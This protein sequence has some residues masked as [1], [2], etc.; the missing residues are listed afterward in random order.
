MMPMAI[1]MIL[2]PMVNTKEPDAASSELFIL[3]NGCGLIKPL[4]CG[5]HI[6]HLAAKHFLERICPTPSKFKKHTH[7]PMPD[8]N[9]DNDDDVDDVL[10]KAIAL[11][12]QVCVISCYRSV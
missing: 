4:R 9:I 2:S 7:N 5:S 8:D 1:S 11:V 10:S 6:I 12:N 3:C